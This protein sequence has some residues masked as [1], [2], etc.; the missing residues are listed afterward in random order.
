MRRVFRSMRRGDMPSKPVL[1]C[2]ALLILAFACVFG[3]WQFQSYS[4]GKDAAWTQ[5]GVPPSHSQVHLFDASRDGLDT[6][7][8]VSNQEDQVFLSSTKD[9]GQWF[10]VE[11]SHISGHYYSAY[12][13]KGQIPKSASQSRS[14]PAQEVI[15]CRRYVWNWETIQDETF[16]ILVE[17]GSVFTWRYF[18]SLR[19]LFLHIFEGIGLGILVMILGFLV[20]QYRKEIGRREQGQAA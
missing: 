10:L 18:P 6:E 13:C 19:R 5:L 16:V 4:S 2:A 1:G 7:I 17:D 3:L 8:L 9:P 20:Y 14:F 12:D 15:E 11:G